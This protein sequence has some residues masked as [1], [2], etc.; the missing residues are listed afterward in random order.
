[1]NVYTHVAMNDLHDDVQA[2]PG[3]PGNGSARRHG[4][5]V[6]AATGE[7]AVP[8]DAPAELVGL[9]SSWKDL[10]TNV[11]SAIAALALQ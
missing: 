1:M 10:P 4:N 5:A 2:L 9:I 11:R 3:M 8:D 7:P 6:A